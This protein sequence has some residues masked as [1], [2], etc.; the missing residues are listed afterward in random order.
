MDWFWLSNDSWSLCSEHRSIKAAFENYQ[1]ILKIEA[2]GISINLIEKVSFLLE[3]DSKKFLAPTNWG[4]TFCH[5][6]D[7]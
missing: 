5:H 7:T 6:F 2:S 3:I 1:L 4:G